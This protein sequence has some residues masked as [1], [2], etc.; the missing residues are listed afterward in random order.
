MSSRFSVGRLEGGPRLWVARRAIR[1]ERRR[2]RLLRRIALHGAR[3]RW[4]ALG[5]ASSRKQRSLLC[6]AAVG[7]EWVGVVPRDLGFSARP[8][9][10]FGGPEVSAF[11]TCAGYEMKRC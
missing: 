6:V 4:G 11:M 8:E 7:R 1:R 3:R 9:E 5:S 10:M 2:G